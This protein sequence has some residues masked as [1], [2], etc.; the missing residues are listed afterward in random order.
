MAVAI[1]GSPPAAGRADSHAGLNLEVQVLL[2]ARQAVRLAL[3]PHR[4]LALSDRARRLAEAARDALCEVLPP[5]R[6]QAGNGVTRRFTG[7]CFDREV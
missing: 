6:P 7:L 5:S 3:T 2:S 1:D 4:A